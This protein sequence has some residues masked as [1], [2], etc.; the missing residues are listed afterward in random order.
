MNGRALVGSL[1]TAASTTASRPKA[2]RSA[3]H[4]VAHNLLGPFVSWMEFR[5]NGVRIE[6][7]G[8]HRSMYRHHG[9]A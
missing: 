2:S 3:T 8:Q 1:D 9:Y 6:P 4:G 5:W 7:F